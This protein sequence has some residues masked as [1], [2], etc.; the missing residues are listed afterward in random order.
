MKRRE[1]EGGLGHVLFAGGLGGLFVYPTV[2]DITI[3]P[4]V[5]CSA[6]LLL[7]L[8]AMIVLYLWLSA[9]ATVRRAA[10]Y[11]VILAASVVG[12]AAA[13]G[14]R[15]LF[16]KSAPVQKANVSF[17]AESAQTIS[18]EKASP[19]ARRVQT[20]VPKSVPTE[21]SN[22]AEPRDIVFV[23]KYKPGWGRFS[24]LDN[25]LKQDA[26]IF[27]IRDVYVSNTSQ[28]LVTLSFSL[29]MSNPE[30]HLRTSVLEGS[31]KDGYGRTMGQDDLAAALNRRNGFGVTSFILSPLTIQPMSTVNGTMAF[32]CDY[33]PGEN[34]TDDYAAL[35]RSEMTQYELQVVDI[36]HDTKATL[37]LPGRGVL[38]IK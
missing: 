6:L 22:A 1:I 9:E 10:K 25:T 26:C 8:G 23:F 3:K 21:T 16:L 2:T 30:T 15:M 34:F 14:G 33:F 28:K 35:A 29:K 17:T 11:W 36:V 7:F 19:S 32:V 37:S 13:L 27:G 18:S 4:L 24:G 5:L 31:G 12:L 38:R 20:I